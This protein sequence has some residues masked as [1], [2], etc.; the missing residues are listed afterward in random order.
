[1]PSWERVFS[2]LYAT[3]ANYGNSIFGQLFW[4]WLVLAASAGGYFATAEVTVYHDHAL[5]LER[6]LS[7]FSFAWHKAFAPFSA[8][9]ASPPHRGSQ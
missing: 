9:N 7:A 8:P 6:L 3:V 2:W 1:M 4:L 5:N